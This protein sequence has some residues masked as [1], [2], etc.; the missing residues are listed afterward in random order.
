MK[1]DEPDG[2]GVANW[3]NK[4]IM[5]KRTGDGPKVERVVRRERP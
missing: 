4:N 2:E 3:I 1:R 5:I